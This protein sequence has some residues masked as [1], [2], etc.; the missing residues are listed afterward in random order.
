MKYPSFWMA[1]SSKRKRI[2]LILFVLLAAV[3]VTIAAAFLPVSPSTAQQIN[4]NL[5]QT[6]TAH[7]ANGTLPAYI[8]INN[9]S[10]C[11]IMF[12]PIIGP[13]FGFVVLGN[14]GYAL[15]AIAQAQNYPAI[16]GVASE[17]VLPIFWLEFICYSTGIAMSLWLTKR[18]WQHRWMELKN[19]AVLIGI[20]AAIL[21][22]SA[23]LEAWLISIG[24]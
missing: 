10:I 4:N 7:K 1:A 6:V 22:G 8:F 20:C 23:L 15:G 24:V 14:T 11:L 13:I 19:T 12:I 9:F 17:L 5:N 21:F 16:L 2:Y 18:I 3:I